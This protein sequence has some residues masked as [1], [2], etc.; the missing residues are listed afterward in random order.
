LPQ[1]S[2]FALRAT[3]QYDNL[4]NKLASP[5]PAVEAVTTSTTAS[6]AASTLPTEISVAPTP[7]VAIPDVSLPDLSLGGD[8]PIVPIAIGAIVVL[9]GVVLLSGGGKSVSTT[10][11]PTT[12]PAKAVSEA[13]SMMDLSIPYDAAARL[14]YDKSDKSMTYDD[15]KTKY[16]ADAVAE[17]KTKQKK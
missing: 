9:A 11:E 15:F 1:R 10:T 3:D 12:T 4:L 8:L 2:A 17:V 5:S 6:D 13:P 14:A 16:E 7:Q